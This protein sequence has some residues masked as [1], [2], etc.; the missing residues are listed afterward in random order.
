[1][2]T[3]LLIV[4]G[5]LAAGQPLLGAD[6]DLKTTVSS[7]VKKL[8]DQPSYGWKTTVE[9]DG[10]GPFGGGAVTGQH[11]KDGY[12]RV[13]MPSFDGSLEF[14]MK[15]GKVAVLFEENWQTLAQATA[16]GGNQPGR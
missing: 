12:T 15:S 1:M 10:R 5:I 9:T 2:R 7:T 11:E 13:S 16:Q 14:V 6:A 3:T 8:A 4:A